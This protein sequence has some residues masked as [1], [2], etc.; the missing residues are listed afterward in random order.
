LLDR[1]DKTLYQSKADGRDRVT[2]ASL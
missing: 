2:L 1:A